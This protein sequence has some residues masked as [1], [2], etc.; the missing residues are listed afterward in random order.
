MIPMCMATPSAAEKPQGAATTNRA[1][2]PEGR[3]APRSHCARHVRVSGRARRMEDFE[4]LRGNGGAGDTV[5]SQR[6]NGDCESEGQTQ[7]WKI[8]QLLGRSTTGH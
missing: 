3:Y 6:H 2:S 1:G 5:V 4:D 8:Q 7:R